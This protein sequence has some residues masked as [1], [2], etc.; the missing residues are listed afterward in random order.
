MSRFF[1]VI[2]VV[3][4]VALVPSV[5]RADTITLTD[6]ANSGVF[7]T[8]ATYGSLSGGPFSATTSGTQFSSPFMTFCLELNEYFNPGVSYNFVKNDGA[9]GGG[10]GREPGDP[11]NYDPVSDA[12]KWLYYQAVS[13]SYSTWYSAAWSADIGAT[14]QYAI[15]GLEDEITYGNLNT[16][17]KGVYD[18]ATNHGDWNSLY[19]NGVRV[20]ALNLSDVAGDRHQDMLASTTAPV[21]EPG[22]MFLLGTGLIGLARVARRRMRK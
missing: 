10:L 2:L 7:G 11:S 16:S 17:A 4:A 6:Y 18:Y 1:G 21:P 12:T 19:T 14:I 20:Y 8:N 15:W 3:L 22:S 13:G 5:A 9:V